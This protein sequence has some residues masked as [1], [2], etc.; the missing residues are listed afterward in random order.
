[1]ESRFLSLHTEYYVVCISL[2]SVKWN[3]RISG[4]IEQRFKICF[5]KNNVSARKLY[6]IVGKIIEL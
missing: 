3:V 5:E 6:F 1:M 4:Y 2:E